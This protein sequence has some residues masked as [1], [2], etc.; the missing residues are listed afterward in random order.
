MD[1]VLYTAIRCA[2]AT[3]EPRLTITEPPSPRRL[4]T[5]LDAATRFELYL[6]SNLARG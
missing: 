6:R 3:R 5:L 1:Y 2:L 4:A